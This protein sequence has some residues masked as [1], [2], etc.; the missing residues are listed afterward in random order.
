MEINIEKLKELLRKE[1]NDNQTL[2]AETLGIERTH[3]NKVLKSNGK[4]AG[5]GF[6]GAII[7]YCNENKLNYEEYIFFS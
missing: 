5:A 7:K 3:V 6:C 1:F 4:G 2:F